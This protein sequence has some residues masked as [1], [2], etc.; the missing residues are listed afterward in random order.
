M[1]GSGMAPWR[2]QFLLVDTLTH[3]SLELRD[4]LNRQGFPGIDVGLA[5][6]RASHEA[7]E[8]LKLLLGSL[9]AATDTQSWMP[10][11]DRS[12]PPVMV[13]SSRKRTTNQ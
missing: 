4:G 3:G 11:V 7:V 9:S 2:F 5:S 13:F 1:E 8:M 6:R 10:I 12:R